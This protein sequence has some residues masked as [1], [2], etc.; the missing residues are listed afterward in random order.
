MPRALAALALLAALAA[1]ASTSEDPT[2]SAA[3]HSHAF[4]P[5]LNAVRAQNDLAALRPEARL[6]AAAETHAADMAEA[7]FISHDGSDGSTMQSRIVATGYPSCASAE[8]IA[9]RATSR[10]EA[11]AQWLESPAHRDNVLRGGMEDFGLA[12]VGGYWVLKLARPC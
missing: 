9:L 10:E 6:A 5:K 4:A 8:N 12:E 1:C 7:D 3:D 11:I 2:R